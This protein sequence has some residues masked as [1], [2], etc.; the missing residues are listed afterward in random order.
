MFI[1]LFLPL[2]EIYHRSDMSIVVD[3][4]NC[5][6]EV[7]INSYFKIVTTQFTNESCANGC[8]TSKSLKSL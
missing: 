2:Y 5:E 1:I 3:K 6:T 4:Y 7:F 8:C